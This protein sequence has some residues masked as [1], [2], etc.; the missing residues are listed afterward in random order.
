MAS[1]YSVCFS[2]NGE[3]E[4]AQ[5]IRAR[6][7]GVGRATF[8]TDTAPRWQQSCD[9][10]ICTTGGMLIRD[11]AAV[12][13]D[14]LTRL[15]EGNYSRPRAFTERQIAA[16]SRDGVRGHIIHLGS[17]AAWYGNPG[18]DD[19]GAFKAALR[20]YCELRRRSAK[21]YGIKISCLGFGGVDTAFW[22]KATRGADPALCATIVPGARRPLTAD[23]AAA[24]V[25]AVMQLPVNV[26]L[27]DALITS[28][29]YQ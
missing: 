18:A 3:G 6:L 25:V 17:N 26:S 8:V 7:D 24:V 1:D 15:Y 2:G 12:T 11:P 19:Y 22:Q 16:M 9:V 4:I 27:S 29:D 20:K 13:E 14:E 28:V 5:A 21:A 10:A 23:E